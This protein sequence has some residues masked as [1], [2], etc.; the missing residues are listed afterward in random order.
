MSNK[1]VICGVDTST[2]PTVYKKKLRLLGRS[3]MF[4]IF[5]KQLECVSCIF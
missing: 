5:Y 2:L 4:V 1:V 3:F